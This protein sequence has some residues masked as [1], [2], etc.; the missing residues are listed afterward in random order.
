MHLDSDRA[1]VLLRGTA[2]SAFLF[3]S[4]ASA[5]AFA[6]GSCVLFNLVTGDITRRCSL[7]HIPASVA[8]RED[9]LWSVGTDMLVRRVSMGLGA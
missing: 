3:V 1:R 6:R 7:N 4:A 5:A 9:A 8:L 2:L